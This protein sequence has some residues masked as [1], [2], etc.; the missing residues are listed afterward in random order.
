MPEG[1]PDGAHVKL[2]DFRHGMFEV[3]FEGVLH[4]LEPSCVQEI[5]AGI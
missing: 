3:E 5:T 1:L 2:V 4:K